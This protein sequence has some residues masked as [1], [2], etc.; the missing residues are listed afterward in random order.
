MLFQ[1]FKNGLIV[2]FARGYP[3][4][5]SNEIIVVIFK[6]DIVE[7][8]KYQHCVSADALVAVNERMICD[9]SESKPC[10]F[11]YQIGIKLIAG[12]CLERS[13]KSRVKH[14]LVAQ[15]VLTA[16]SRNGSRK[17][18]SLQRT[19]MISVQ[20]SPLLTNSKPLFSRIN[21][22]A[23]TN[24]SLLCIRQRRNIWTKK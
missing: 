24:P 19:L 11:G 21:I 23:T 18:M 20:L 9:K 10:G 14:T 3:E 17:V 6:L 7:P 2:I 1:P 4:Y 12:K 15:S 5:Q 22:A 16:V 13:V 8:E